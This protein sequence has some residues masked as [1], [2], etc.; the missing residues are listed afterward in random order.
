MTFEIESEV[1]A[2]LSGVRSGRASGSTHATSL[3]DDNC[4]RHSS[5]RYVRSRRNSVSRPRCVHDSSFPVSSTRA[6]DV[7][8]IA[9]NGFEADLAQMGLYNPAMHIMRVERG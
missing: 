9:C 2:L 4:T 5:A 7:V 8:T 3:L 6:A 1:N